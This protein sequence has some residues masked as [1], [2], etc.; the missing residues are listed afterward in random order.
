MKH[1]WESHLLLRR[2]E[3]FTC[4]TGA[5]EYQEPRSDTTKKKLTTE[6][7]LITLKNNLWNLYMDNIKSG[8]K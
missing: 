2:K 7:L 3:S 8:L 6:T 5:A 4:V 1:W